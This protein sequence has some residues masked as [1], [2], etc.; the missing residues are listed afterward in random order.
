MKRLQFTLGKSQGVRNTGGAP[1][2]T[3]YRDSLN[4]IFQSVEQLKLQLVE[5]MVN[6]DNTEVEILTWTVTIKGCVSEGDTMITILTK[7]VYNLHL[8]RN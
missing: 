4:T 6:N 2:I 3:R 5:E 1:L 8:K 7:C